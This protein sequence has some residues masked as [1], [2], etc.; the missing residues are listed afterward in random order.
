MHAF[1]PAL[2]AFVIEAER[3]DHRGQL[4][5]EP[6]L[7]DRLQKIERGGAGFLVLGPGSDHGAHGV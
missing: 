4:A 2:P 5:L 7:H 6:C 3:V 1:D